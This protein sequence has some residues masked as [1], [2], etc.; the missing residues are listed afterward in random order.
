M[1]LTRKQIHEQ[2]YYYA[3][4]L[5]AVSLPLSNYFISVF[6]F[7]L[8]ANWLA[9][10]RF[11][12]KWERV[13]SNRALQVF[14]LIFFLNAVG[15]IWTD[16]LV[17]GL[18]L[19]KV[20]LPLLALPLIIASSAPLDR[21]RVRRILLFF[22]ASVFVAS[23]ASV[24]KLAGWLPGGI[25]GYRD[26]SLFINHIRF[27]LMIVLAFLIAVYFQFFYGNELSKAERIFFVVILIW[28]P[29]FI[30]A[31][32]SLTG[33]FVGGFLCFLL[34]LRL[35][36]SIR[37]QVYRFMALVFMAMI[38]LLPL[39]YLSASMDRFY[40]FEE[41]KPGELDKYTIQGNRYH[42]W[43]RNKEV[44]NG[45]YVWVHVCKEELE[46]EW[47]KV[48][49]IDYHS[50]T[51]TG[52]PLSVTLI[53]YLT[54]KGL[55][56]DAAAVRQLT[57]EEIRAIENGTT[58]Y[59]FLNHF[60]LYPRI[61]EVIWEFYS[62]SIGKT[63]NDKSVLQRYIYLKAGWAIARENLLY[64]V[65]TGDVLQEFKA[66]YEK[67]NSPFYDRQRRGAH[68]EYLSA[69]IAF[70]LGGLIILVAALIVPL[71]LARRQDSFLAGGFLSILMISMLASGTLDSSNGAAFTGLF[72]SLFL[73]GPSF[74]WVKK[75]APPKI[76]E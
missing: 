57:E 5:I 43:T 52:E 37:S 66:Y 60:S 11:R 1:P 25:G 30:L 18:H 14:L 32:K 31:L 65:G 76:H 54:S 49:S 56:K 72:Y 53:R 13:K 15:M 42:H 55:R 61:Y 64:G 6:Q 74:P 33:I 67:T 36:L 17:F 47:N 9:E 70:G 8:L 4:I 41:L 27:A 58:N 39:M 73:F 40:D 29:L 22:S 51:S 45:H 20:K 19:M 34:L 59:I 28:F 46:E 24:L 50:H 38:P 2:V 10:L 62:Y 48:S 26:L 16:N 63:P 23:L 3:L 44:E 12:E 75:T 35:V 69:L 7:L 21:L 68:N 71:F